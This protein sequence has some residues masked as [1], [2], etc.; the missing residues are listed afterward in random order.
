ME[1]ERAIF[2]TF[3]PLYA[4]KA[5][6]PRRRVCYLQFFEEGLCKEAPLIEMGVQDVLDCLSPDDVT[7]RWL[8]NQMRTF[9]PYSQKVIGLVFERKRVVSD[10]LWVK[11]RRD[12]I[13]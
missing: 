4:D 13:E 5:S 11:T 1:K 9:D 2:R 12:E 6:C 3:L 10:V 7:V 8:L